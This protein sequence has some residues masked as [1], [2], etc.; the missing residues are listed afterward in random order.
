MAGET[1]KGAFELVGLMTGTDDKPT[2]SIGGT[3]L[4]C[5]IT[6][7]EPKH[8]DKVTENTGSN[9]AIVNVNA[10]RISTECALTVV[11]QAADLTAALAALG[12]SQPYPL[13]KITIAGVHKSADATDIPNG[14]W[15]YKDGWSTA[16]VPGERVSIKMNLVRYVGITV[17]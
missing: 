3:A 17:V 15:F 10:R 12:S 4:A 7:C 14:D 2:V 13:A 9:A 6:G 5:I 16:F 1:Q 11:V 8:N